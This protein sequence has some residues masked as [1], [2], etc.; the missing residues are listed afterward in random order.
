M[1]FKFLFSALFLVGIPIASLFAQIADIDHVRYEVLSIGSKTCRVLT[2]DL[3]LKG[4][5]VIP[6]SV[7]IDGSKYGVIR[8]GDFAFHGRYQMRGVVLPEILQHID[9]GAF[10]NCTGLI[11][12]TLPASLESIG[13]YAFAQCSQ[14]WRFFVAPDNRFFSTD[15]DYALF[16]K[17]KT[18]LYYYPS[19]KMVVPDTKPYVVPSTVEHIGS[20]AF[21]NNKGLTAITFPEGLKT[22]G[23]SA[24]S[25]CRNLEHFDFPAGLESIGKYCFEFDS[26]IKEVLIPVGV[27]KIGE[28]VFKDCSSLRAINVAAGNDNYVSVGG[29]LYTKDRTLFVAYPAASDN[30]MLKLDE[31]VTSVGAAAFAGASK[32]LSVQLPEGLTRIGVSAFSTCEGLKDFVVP[33]GVKRIPQDCFWSCTNLEKVVLKENVSYIGGTAFAFCDALKEIELP[34]SV[35]HIMGT[36]FDNSGIQVIKAWSPEPPE[37]S[38]G[39]SEVFNA[40]GCVV[41]V[42]EKSVFNYKITEGWSLFKEIKPLQSTGMQAVSADFK[43]CVN[44]NTLVLTGN[45]AGKMI[46]VYSVAG[47][48]VYNGAM[49]SDMVSID[50]PHSG[51]YFVK[52]GDKTLKVRIV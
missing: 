9:D 22:I 32:L 20:Y 33:A 25:I 39:L 43:I 17:S 35:Y 11:E 24:F 8:I 21:F 15:N 46:H 45:I 1:N 3:N 48:L 12:I 34:A 6:D 42:P 7:T 47:N 40:A 30:S 13:E 16:D 31:R 52:I 41:Y 29:N 51:I 37:W 44:G 27:R 36:A 28:G 2:S 4:N 14:L 10:M 26:K 49:T 5:V 50:L 38:A 19:G 18:T 23:A